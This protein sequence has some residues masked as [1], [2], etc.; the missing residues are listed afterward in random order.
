MGMAG[1]VDGDLVHAHRQIGAVIEVKAA[2]EILIGFP[3][4]RMLGDDHA[5]NFLHHFGGT[6]QGAKRQVGGAYHALVGGL[7]DAGKILGAPVTTTVSRVSGGASA[8][9]VAAESIS[10]GKKP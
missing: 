4:A 2:Q 9:A 6:Q 1:H 3:A 5:G 10:A 7:G 8:R